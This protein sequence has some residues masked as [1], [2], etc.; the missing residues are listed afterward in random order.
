MFTRVLFGKPAEIIC[1][2]YSFHFLQHVFV[3]ADQFTGHQREP[4]PHEFAV[5][6]MLARLIVEIMVKFKKHPITR[7]PF[8][9][10]TDAQLFP[11]HNLFEI[12]H[13]FVKH[14]GKMVKILCVR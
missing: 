4:A 10:K 3:H 5:G 7:K 2:F 1:F 8:D 9:L 13:M 11:G 12:P 14:K 6:D